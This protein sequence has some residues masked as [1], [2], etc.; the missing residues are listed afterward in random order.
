MKPSTKSSEYLYQ[1]AAGENGMGTK[2]RERE[3]EKESSRLT[4]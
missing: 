1:K 4:E 3:R 2:W